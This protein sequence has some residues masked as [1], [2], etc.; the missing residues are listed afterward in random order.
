VLEQKGGEEPEASR[1]PV[2]DGGWIGRDF[3]RFGALDHTR[4]G[5]RRLRKQSI[6]PVFGII[7]PVLEV[8]SFS[9][10]GWKG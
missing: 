3:C 8:R 5:T 4:A 9:L 1:Q 6:E 7:A 2:E 10:R